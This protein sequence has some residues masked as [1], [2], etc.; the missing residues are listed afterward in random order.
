MCPLSRRGWERI[1]SRNGY[2]QSMRNTIGKVMK[3]K[4]LSFLDT[5]GKFAEAG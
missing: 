5:V 4:M 1:G 3:R 2:W